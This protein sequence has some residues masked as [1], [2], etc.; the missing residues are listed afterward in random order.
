MGQ[1]YLSVHWD[2]SALL[3]IDMQHDFVQG[4]MPVPGTLEIL[5]VVARAAASFRAAGR[6]V[7][8]VIRYYQPGGT[9]VD[10]VRRA[11]VQAGALIA[12]PGTTGAS[13]PPELIGDAVALDHE[14]LLAGRIQQVGTREVVMFKP[15][16]SAFFRTDLDSWLT[17]HGIDSVVLAGCNLPNCPRATIFDASARDYRVAL[18]TDA[19][20]QVTAERL[21]DLQAIGVQLLST[22]QLQASLH[23]A[24]QPPR[25]P[26]VDPP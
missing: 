7:V 22:T 2:R 12:A 1:D 15:R 5:P 17:Q 13:I 6:P 16:W 24:C 26:G 14:A 9:D 4:A 11:T 20:S 19:V 10:A 23:E 3:V 21:T 8:H 25:T 18:V